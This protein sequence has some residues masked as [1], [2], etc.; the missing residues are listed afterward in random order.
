MRV[1]G[2][3]LAA[4]AVALAAP[5]ARAEPLSWD[6][7]H[8]V[9]SVEIFTT[10]A[11][12]AGAVPAMLIEP[13]P[14]PWR[15]TNGFDEAWRN[16]VRAPSVG[17]RQGADIASS[18]LLGAQGAVLLVD[19]WPVAGVRGRGVSWQMTWIDAQAVA[20]NLF[21]QTVV[22][23]GI[24]RERPY[25]R[26]CSASPPPSD[27]DCTG[28]FRYQSFYSGHTSTAFTFAGLTCMHHAH[29]PLWGGG[30]PDVTACALA[31]AA[32]V[33]TGVLRTVADKHYLSDV[34]TGA[35]IG[36]IAG[37]GVPW[38]YYRA[39]ALRPTPDVR[40]GVSITVV[41]GPNGAAV[42]GAF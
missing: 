20:I 18:V 6:G 1:L 42:T 38:L 14:A 10:V 13:S 17:T 33:T 25:G 35:G 32:A 28:N 7:F 36:A 22:S 2:G 11:L 41:P 15:Q 31:S 24:S 39:G 8:P 29:L 30:A 40:S 34:L 23:H 27:A 21:L 26:N 37:L 3:L 12:F 16:L 9:G 19:A 4:L 5:A